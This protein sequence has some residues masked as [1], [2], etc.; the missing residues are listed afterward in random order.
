MER[1]ERISI[2]DLLPLLVAETNE[3][4]W[5]ILPTEDD[6]AY[7]AALEDAVL[8]PD[9]LKDNAPKLVFTPIH[10]TGAIS[11]IPALWDHGVE[12][13]VVDEQNNI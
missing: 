9:I 7:R 6:L 4:S 1:Y 2:Q 11:A 8:D 5:N 12:V 13:A 3:E 10:G